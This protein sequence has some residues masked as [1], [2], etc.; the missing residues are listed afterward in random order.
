MMQSIEIIAISNREISEPLSPDSATF[1]IILI[2]FLN[3]HALLYLSFRWLI[4]YI[5]RKA[6]EASKT[7]LLD[8]NFWTECRGMCLSLNLGFASTTALLRS[9]RVHSTRDR[10]K[11]AASGRLSTQDRYPL[12]KYKGDAVVPAYH[13]ETTYGEH[14]ENGGRSG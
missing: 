4:M 7:F 3:G 2:I 1:G 5:S 12:T 14:P 9:L 8:P 11:T 13:S 10:L 6:K